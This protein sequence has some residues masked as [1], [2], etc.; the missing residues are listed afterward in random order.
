MPAFGGGM[1]ERPSALYQDR[2]AA[3]WAL[4]FAHDAEP[5]GDVA[6]GLDQAAHAL[7]EAILVELV[8]GLDVP[9][10]ARVRG[11]LVGHHDP[12]QIVFP[13][14]A[15]FHLEVDQAD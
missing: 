10:P 12:H 15:A 4:V 1:T 14:P 5:P 8:V 13:Q 7:A 6:V 2:A 11:N 3:L 9:Q